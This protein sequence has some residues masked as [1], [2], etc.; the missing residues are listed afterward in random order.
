L[1]KNILIIGVVV[2]AAGVVESLS[3]R[4][5]GFFTTL[6]GAVNI[7]LGVATGRSSGVTI[8]ETGQNAPRL[9]V[10]RAVLR[11]GVCL[12]AFFDDKLVIKKLTSAKVTMLLSILLF[13]VGLLFDGLIGGL[14]GGLTGYSLQ[15]Y[16]GQSRRN[17]IRKMNTAGN[18]GRGDVQVD[19]GKIEKVHARRSSLL[20]VA[21]GKIVRIN[22]PR[23]Y[24]D[25]VKPVLE[26]LLDEKYE[27]ELI[28]QSVSS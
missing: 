17:R 26:T 5:I 11:S 23:G 16:T 27:E 15:E 18:A 3:L 28:P 12:L 14:S 1:R 6:A 9:L 10:D 8:D 19:Y 13:V 4:G 20:V 22:L 25:R 7:L 24:V 2:T 21:E